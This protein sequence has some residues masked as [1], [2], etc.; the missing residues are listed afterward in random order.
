M[1]AW[2]PSRRR[3]VTEFN[4]LYRLWEGF[5]VPYKESQMAKPKLTPILSESMISPVVARRG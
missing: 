3:T 5:W 1:R 4:Y 2:R